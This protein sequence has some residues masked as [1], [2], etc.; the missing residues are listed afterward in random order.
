[1][2]LYDTSHV[3]WDAY[4]QPAVNTLVLI[5]PDNKVVDI[6]TIGQS[7]ALEDKAVAMASEI[8]DEWDWYDPD[9]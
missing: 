5:D 6:K 4:K 2:C 9:D 1:M 3:A 8:Y 7:K